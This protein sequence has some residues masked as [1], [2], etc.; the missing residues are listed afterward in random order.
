[1]ADDPVEAYVC[2]RRAV[3]AC[4]HY[5]RPMSAEPHHGSQERF[6]ERPMPDREVL[7]RL[8]PLRHTCCEHARVRHDHKQEA[9]TRATPRRV[10]NADVIGV[11]ITVEVAAKPASDGPQGQVR[12]A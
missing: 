6:V 10:P 12:C 8:V 5:L 3:G 9:A 7:W 1:A 4:D 11:A 2:E